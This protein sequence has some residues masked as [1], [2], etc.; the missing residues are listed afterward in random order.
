MKTLKQAAS[1]NGTVISNKD[2]EMVITL[3]PTP[4]VQIS[5]IGEDTITYSFTGDVEQDTVYTPNL[6]FTYKGKHRVVVPLSLTHKHIE[7][8]VL[9]YEL[10][11]TGDLT[12]FERVQLYFT[13]KDGNGDPV[14][15]ATKVDFKLVT[16]PRTGSVVTSYGSGIYQDPNTPGRYYIVVTPGETTGTITVTLTV[17]VPDKTDSYVLDDMVFNNPGT[18]VV[19]TPVPN[20]A[21]AVL[22]EVTDITLALTKAIS[23]DPNSPAVG[24]VRI[25]GFEGP[26]TLGQQITNTE[27]PGTYSFGIKS[28]GEVG[29]VTV[30]GTY[31][32]D[33]TASIYPTV[34]FSFEFEYVKAITLTAKVVGSTELESSKKNT[35]QFDVV[36][37]DNVPVSGLL[38]DGSLNAQVTPLF[39]TNQ[40]D[41]GNFFPVEGTPGRYYWT[42]DLGPV[43][44][45]LTVAPK[46]SLGAFKTTL[47][48]LTY[49]APGKAV[50]S[51]VTPLAITVDKDTQVE[52]TLKQERLNNSSAPVVGELVLQQSGPGV[53]I[54]T[55]F[56][57]KEGAPGTYVG[58]IK[59]SNVG[60]SGQFKFTID[61]DW[62][63][64]GNIV[65]WV[66]VMCQVNVI[67]PVNF[68]VIGNSKVNLRVGEQ[69]TLNFYPT[70]NGEGTD[71][72]IHL[73][74]PTS[75]VP[76]HVS[77]V[78]QGPGDNGSYDVVVE[79]LQNN[80]YGDITF[81]FY[82]DGGSP[83]GVIGEDRV[84]VKTSVV[85]LGSLTVDDVIPQVYVKTGDQVDITLKLTSETDTISMFSDG[86]VV[87][88]NKPDEVE[89][90]KN[91]E[92]GFTIKSL[93]VPDQGMNTRITNFTITY[94]ERTVSFDVKVSHQT[95]NPSP[96]VEVIGEITGVN[97]DS[98]KVPV[99]VTSRMTP[100]LD[101]T[102]A[103]VEWSV[104]PNDYIDV[105][106]DGTWTIK[107]DPETTATGEFRFSFRIP[108]QAMKWSDN[109]Q[110]KYTIGNSTG[111]HLEGLTGSYEMDLWDTAPLV[112][113]IKAGDQDITS[114]LTEITCV[115]AS[116][117]SQQFEFVKISDTSWGF[118]SVKADPVKWQVNYASL[119]FKVTHEGNVFDLPA[120]VKLST[121]PNSGGIPTT[122]FNIE[123]L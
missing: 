9:T 7:T 80:R 71:I 10:E 27:T 97:G 32:N 100:G 62:N 50:I 122:R 85:C 98:G 65:Q 28:T 58:T 99:K 38:Y 113:S 73:D 102:D 55:Q 47:N 86:L 118:K 22:N 43:A 78:G 4:G 104:T 30:S 54:I 37:Q 17:T 90:V 92:G 91:I 63:T 33:S 26:A 3:D 66:D 64:T 14:I 24:T 109:V 81:N 74:E 36:D 93:W 70:I 40:G 45:E 11:T 12:P 84:E 61:E 44:C 16:N 123:F 119:M 31:N 23:S 34:P 35:I 57:P 87:T 8:Y 111:P 94:H 68:D 21:P 60:E 72:P 82:R 59:S 46:V 76:S 49:S 110:I 103:T 6:T 2:P 105:S 69:K 75:T 112:F 25:T 19:A 42:V 120:E 20:S 15:G 107:K 18:L 48:T 5:D 117:I 96:T 51:T 115:N 121:R 116:E 95:T 39:G 52:V 106:P 108:E 77:I 89:I 1:V 13:L 101:L 56:V 79:G 67:P 114:E 29:K 88:T 41:S 83:T 53:E